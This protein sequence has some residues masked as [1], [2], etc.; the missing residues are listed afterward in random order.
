MRLRDYSTIKN[1]ILSIVIP[2]YHGEKYVRGLIE[3]LERNIKLYYKMGK[4]GTFEVIFIN[5]SPD[6]KVDTNLFVSDVVDI[7]YYPLN[8][9]LGIHGARLHGIYKSSGK[10][11]LLL[12][13]DDELKDNYLISQLDKVKISGCVVCNGYYRKSQRIYVSKE[14]QILDLS[15]H[16]MLKKCRIISPGQVILLKSLIPKIWFNLTMKNNG[17][18]DYFLWLCLLESG[19]KFTV[20]PKLLYRHREHGENHSFDWSNMI[21]SMRELQDIITKGNVISCQESC[22][23]FIRHNEACIKKFENYM[24][25]DQILCRIDKSNLE[26]KN[27]KTVALYGMGVFGWKIYNLIKD[28]VEVTYAIDERACAMDSNVINVLLPSDY[29]PPVDAIIVTI[30]WCF[31]DVKRKLSKKCDCPIIDVYDVFSP[32]VLHIENHISLQCIK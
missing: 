1:I 20:N 32:D 25:L 29:M 22:R 19:V 23:I 12:D 11:L 21:A 31:K 4:I 14:N 3:L 13:Q 10:Y 26:L 27:Y 16:Q 7:K 6:D 8:K 15:Y 2:L 5:D 30:H 9:N 18:D 17:L 24:H 28:C